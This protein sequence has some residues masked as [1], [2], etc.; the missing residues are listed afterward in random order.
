MLTRKGVIAACALAL[1]YLPT[2]ALA[3]DGYKI[4]G[5]SGI[6]YFVSVSPDQKDNEDVYRMAVGEAC[7]GKQMCQVQFWVGTAP[8]GFPLTDKQASAKIAQWQL[9]LNTGLRRWLVQCRATT[10]FGNERECM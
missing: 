3:G 4:T 8:S 5:R 9:N 2:T 7:A 10:L 6:M 1:A